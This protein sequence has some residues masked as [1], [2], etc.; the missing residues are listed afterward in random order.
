MVDP[1]GLEM[2][3]ERQRDLRREAGERRIA[4]ALREAR[5]SAGRETSP[6][7]RG[8]AVE[9]GRVV[10][11][12]G[13]AEDE[14]TVADLLELNGVPRWVAF[15][16]RFIVAQRDGEVL[17]ALRYRT[18]SKR[19]LLGLLTVDPWA[20]EMR[21]A[22]A[23]YRGAGELA[24]ELGVGE[25]VASEAREGYPGLAGY[26]RRGRSWRLDSRGPRVAATGPRSPR[27]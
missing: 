2:S 1:F 10:V 23:L 24:R 22:T 25:I 21:L 11:R 7:G 12:W 9:E 5:R 19:L 20:G 15:E 18:E 26:W 16:D 8:A 6:G 4:R 3:R 14:P 13:L 17:G 27:G